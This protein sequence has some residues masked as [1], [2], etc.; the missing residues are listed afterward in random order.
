MGFILLPITSKTERIV[1][2]IVQDNYLVNKFNIQYVKVGLKM[3]FMFTYATTTNKL[4]LNDESEIPRFIDLPDVG[5]QKIT[6]I[7]KK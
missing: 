4:F 7:L 3:Q 6:S 5:K 1:E 2:N